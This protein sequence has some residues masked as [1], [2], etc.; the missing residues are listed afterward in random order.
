MIVDHSQYL[1]LMGACVLLTAPLELVVGA[2][3]YRRP[4][5]AVAAILPTLCIFAAWDWLA[6]ERGEWWFAARYVSGLRV[7]MLPVEELAF[8]VAISLCTLLTY[9]TVQR[10]LR[11]T[12]RDA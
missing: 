7:G 6:V 9:D 1:L 11:R 12:A 10:L 5:R 4:A 3:V 8:F 2:R